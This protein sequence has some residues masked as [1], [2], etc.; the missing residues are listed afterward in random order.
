M[1][2]FAL[3]LLAVTLIGFLGAINSDAATIE[4]RGLPNELAVGEL[5][6]VEVWAD[7][8]FIAGDAIL[9]FGFD[10]VSSDPAISFLSLTAVNTTFFEDTSSHFDNTDVSGIT[11]SGVTADT[12]RLATLEC[13][14][15]S[16]GRA[17]LSILSDPT[18]LNE[19]LV[20]WKFGNLDFSVQTEINVIP[21]PN[22]IMLLS[23]GILL[24]VSV[25]LVKF[26]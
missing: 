14:A 25:K 22:S 21:I 2:K 8:A 19:G 26:G 18:D 3:V 1:K 23:M 20:Y 13:T 4:I 11:M 9:G 5:L 12:F 15:V 6:A 10:L 16:P 17:T 24:I 7:N